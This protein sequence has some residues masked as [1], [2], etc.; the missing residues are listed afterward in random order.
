VRHELV[1]VI[2]NGPAVWGGG[3]GSSRS[4]PEIVNVPI[5]ELRSGESPRL[6]GQDKAHIARLAQLEMPLPPILVDRRSN[7]VIDGM[8][9]LI[10]ASLKGQE[11]V[12]VRY[13]DGRMED[14]F[15]WAVKE[16]VEHGLPLSLA[17]RRAA[18][19]RI[20]LSHPE[21]SDRALAKWVGLAA[22]TVASIRRRV[23]ADGAPVSSVR[24][25]RDGKVRPLD[26]SEGRHRV[27]A[28]VAEDPDAS[29]RELAR[30]A[31]VSPATVRDVRHRLDRGEPPARSGAVPSVRTEQPVDGAGTR[32]EAPASPDRLH[33]PV[34][35]STS[36]PD[37]AEVSALDKL[38]RDPSLRGSEPGR[39]LLRL[40]QHHAA[41]VQEW[42]AVL[43]ALPLHCLGT[44][45][46]LARQHS[47][48]WLN[49]AQEL[50]DRARIMDPW[51]ND[52]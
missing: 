45:E 41:T 26:G 31:G 49:F 16:N 10:A 27:A 47:E 21:L 13:F 44:V 8:H 50:D 1:S 25:G 22:R 28:L 33:E 12:E 29:L 3:A 6:N 48:M 35:T 14:A 15:L 37:P 17:D 30:R 42:P 36:S 23:S 2:P 4:Q 46:Q 9:R 32:R 40:L 43:A 52:S 24:L 39:Y 34:A 20:V 38:L 18:A 11:T 19:A 5:S 51:A 7:K